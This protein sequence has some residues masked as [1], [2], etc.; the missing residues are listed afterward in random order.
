MSDESL[1]FVYNN[2]LAHKLGEREMRPEMLDDPFESGVAL[3]NIGAKQG[4]AYTGEW[5]IGKDIRQGRGL[6]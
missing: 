6:L 5:L 2:S 4:A 1:L 3:T